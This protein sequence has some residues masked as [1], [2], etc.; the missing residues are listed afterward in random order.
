MKIQATDWDYAHA[1]RFEQ[2]GNRRAALGIA[3]GAHHAA[4]LVQN[5]VNER[6]GHQPIAV[7]LDLGL[8]SIDPNS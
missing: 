8:A 7:N 5:D 6:F 2:L 4:R 3:Q 1:Y